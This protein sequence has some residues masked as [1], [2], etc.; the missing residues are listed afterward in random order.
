MRTGEIFEK[1]SQNIYSLIISKLYI[2]ISNY[3]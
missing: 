3:S 1:M 2:I